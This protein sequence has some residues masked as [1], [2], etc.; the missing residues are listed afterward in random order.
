MLLIQYLKE[1][2]L[3]QVRQKQDQ[4]F[5]QWVQEI[6]TEFLW[7]KKLASYIGVMLDQ[8]QVEI[9]LKKKALV[10]MMN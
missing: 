8:M 6:R 4:K 10:V 9:S 7:I 1:I 2:Y 5:M 3:N